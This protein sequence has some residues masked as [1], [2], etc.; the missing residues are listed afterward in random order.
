MP[1]LVYS[2]KTSSRLRILD[3]S[4]GIGA[5]REALIISS[6]AFRISSL[7]PRSVS[8]SVAPRCSFACDKGSKGEVG[9]PRFLFGRG[10]K[11]WVVLEKFF[12]ST[13]LKLRG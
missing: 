8:G 3:C 4:L 7:Y 10:V 12:K 9:A 5:I 1:F 6:L 2:R 11:R 13:G